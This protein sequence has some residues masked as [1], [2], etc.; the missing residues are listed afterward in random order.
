MKSRYDEVADI[1]S[2]SHNLPDEAKDWLNRFVAEFVCADFNHGGDHIHVTPEERSK[3]WSKNNNRNTCT[4]NREK[5]Y[6][7]IKYIE[8]LSVNNYNMEDQRN[9]ILDLDDA[10]FNQSDDNTKDTN[11]NKKSTL[12]K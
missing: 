11:D 12:T 5:S 1:A 9:Y 2:Y 8:D 4:Y 6:G 10:E 7:T 3:C